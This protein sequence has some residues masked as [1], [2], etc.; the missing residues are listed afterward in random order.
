MPKAPP[1]DRLTNRAFW[2]SYWNT[3][4]AARERNVFDEVF[5]RYL[6][7]GGDYLEIG[8]S[9]GWTL[10]YF[11]RNF[12]YRVTGVDFVDGALVRRTMADHGIRTYEFI[13][14]DFF[15]F[16]SP[17]RFDVVGS[18]GFVE[19]FADFPAVLRRQ[20]SFVRP[21]GHLVVE[22]PN[23]RYFNNL[24][25]RIF[26][27]KVLAMHNLVAMDLRALTAPL[28]EDFHLVYA[29]YFGTCFLHFDEQNSF[30]SS[31]PGLLRLVHGARG[32][33]AAARLGNVPSRFLS[34]Y[35]LVIAQRA[36]TE[37]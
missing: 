18:F 36:K 32:L 15:E 20:A 35:I 5:R 19:H 11:H 10:A 31:R 8:C 30:L 21:G 37:P 1:D 17:R 7:T 28:L 2:E 29:R 34:P 13:E 14:A 6:P 24:L 23:L 9:P 27:P 25:Y 22:V 26:L 3:S 12:G 33:L 16:S 4:P